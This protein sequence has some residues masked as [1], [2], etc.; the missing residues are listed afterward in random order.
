MAV[1]NAQVINPVNRIL[2]HQYEVI[3]EAKVLELKVT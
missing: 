1:I 3:S 2:A